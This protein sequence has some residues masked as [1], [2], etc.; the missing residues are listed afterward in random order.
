MKSPYATKYT[1]ECRNGY[2]SGKRNE[3][4]NEDQRT[5]LLEDLENVRQR[6]TELEQSEKERTEAER[7]LQEDSDRYRHAVDTAPLSVLSVDVQGRIRYANSQLRKKFHLDLTDPEQDQDVMSHPSFAQTGLSDAFRQCL[8]TQKQNVFEQSLDEQ[9]GHQS[10]FRY[11]LS[12]IIDKDGSINGVLAVID[13]ITQQKRT[14]LELSGRLQAE[15]HLTRLFSKLIGVFDIDLALNTTLAEL[16][17][18]VQ[19]ER[20]FLYLIYEKGTKMDNTHEW[21]A[22]GVSPQIEKQQNLATASFSWVMSKLEAGESL[23]IR[24]LEDLPPEAEQERSWLKQLEMQSGILLPVKVKGQL[25][26]FLGLTG[27][28]P[29]AAWDGDQVQMLQTAADML[30]DFLDQKR[31]DDLQKERDEHFRRLAHA[32]LE[33]LFILRGGRVVDANQMVGSML[34][35]EPGDYRGKDFTRFFD[36]SDLPAVKAYL[37]AD[38][39]ASIETAIKR[40]DGT[41]LPVELVKRTLKYQDETMSVVALRD[42]SA[43]QEQASSSQES[44]SNFRNTLDGMLRTLSLSLAMRDPYAA[45]HGEGVADLACAIAQEMKLAEDRIEGLRLTGIIHDIGKI[46]L[47]SEILSKPGKIS[48]AERM[49]VEN[50]PKI[51]FDMLKDVKFP[52][53]V[54]KSVLMHHERMNGTGYPAGLSGD[55]IIL[56]ARIL[57]V[58]DIVDAMV[59]DRSHRPARGLE[60]AVEEITRNQGTLYDPQ[61]VEAAVKVINQRGYPFKA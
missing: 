46:G 38:P 26:G 25:I 34:G 43:R 59:S 42:I 61:V 10:W 16:G 21:S 39:G 5:K 31:A 7:A 54:A 15:K 53:P 27:S 2:V 37:K 22:S 58:A 51:G 17:D 23:E 14:E 35:L 9:N 44:V 57:A 11:F 36:S 45:G 52:W 41:R 47:P 12:P 4:M 30:G 60:N 20:S 8:E 50:H 56:E 6:I 55:S 1:P 33:G 19:V 29:R 49:M 40:K 18:I 13:D 3:T 32:A 24:A 48:E 28:K